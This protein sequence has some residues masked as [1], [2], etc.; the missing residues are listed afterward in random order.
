MLPHTAFFDARTVLPRPSR[1][2]RSEALTQVRA[3]SRFR[4]SLCAPISLL[5]L[6]Y[7]SWTILRAISL[8][9]R[10]ARSSQRQA[11]DGIA[12]LERCPRRVQETVPAGTRSAAGVPTRRAPAPERVGAWC[13]RWDQC[14]LVA[15]WLAGTRRSL[16]A[17]RGRAR[18]RGCGE[19]PP[20]SACRGARRA[21]WR[22]GAASARQGPAGLRT[23]CDAHGARRACAR[24]SS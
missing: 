13:L 18:G 5:P 14:A 15:T 3:C 21:P 12:W 11:H 22:L 1:R 4:L 20:H 17:G 23:G 2:R 10:P 8:T 19:T 9:A 24:A 7:M 6:G 16:T